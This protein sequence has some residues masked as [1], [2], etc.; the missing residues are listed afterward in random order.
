MGLFGSGEAAGSPS[1]EA[2]AIDERLESVYRSQERVAAL[3]VRPHRRNDG[4]EAMA[5]V[6]GAV[7]DVETETGTFGLTTE[8]VSPPFAYEVRYAPPSPGE[9]RVLSLS[10]AT[11]DRSQSGL[12]ERQLRNRYPASSITERERPFLPVEAGRHVAGATLA[13]DRYALYPIKH[14]DH[15]EF[16]ANPMGSILDELAGGTANPAAGADVGLQFLFRPARDGW[17]SG[18]RGGWGAPD[19]DTGPTLL[20]GGSPPSVGELAHDLTQP[21]YER[22]WKLFTPETVEVPP[23]DG[24]RAAAA[25]LRDLEGQKGWRVLVRL[26]AVGDDPAVVSERVETV[27]GL[28]RSFHDPRTDQSLS[29]APLR[30]GDLRAEL[31][32]ANAREWRETGIVAAQRELA[33]LVGLPRE[34]A[35][36]T[37]ALPWVRATPGKGIQP[38]TPRFDFAAHGVADADDAAKQRAMLAHGEPDAPYWYGWGTRNGTEAGVRADVLATHQFVGGATGQG[39]TTLLQHFFRQVMVRGAGGLFYDPKGMDS[40]ELLSLV[41]PDREDDLVFVEVGGDP[42]RRAG[43]NVLEPPTDAPPEAATFGDAVERTTEDV[44]ALLGGADPASD[45]WGVRVDRLTRD[46]ARAMARDGYECT[47]VDLYLVL[48]PERDRRAFADLV[49]ED[50]LDWLDEYA[51][52]AVDEETRAAARET[53]ARLRAVVENE[54]VR[55]VIAR[56]DGVSIRGV[57]ADGKLVIVRDRSAQADAGRTVATA[58]LRRLWVAVREQTLADDQPDPPQFSAVIDEF[59]DVAAAEAEVAS[60]LSKARSFGLSLTVACQDLSGQLEGDVL[61]AIEGQCQTFLTFNPGRT[62]DA[63]LIANH[64]SADVSAS[65]LLDLS[66]YRI[67]LRTQDDDGELTHSYKVQ[68]FPPLSEMDAA[69]RA[70]ADVAALRERSLGRY[71]TGD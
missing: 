54:T 70:E 65:D 67:Y 60:I 18:V 9:E 41:P 55:E 14:V 3:A 5:D 59:D 2:V 29:A 63:E 31:R 36:S 21:S 45:V 25:E 1:C 68:T 33:T 7:H 51:A 16:A 20:G 15:P 12:L 64:H 26:F 32:R 47:L 11:T 53:R 19:P 13:L 57:V 71:G 50:R 17:T 52:A 40:E 44:A 30:V 61:D 4:V 6:L 46:L 66:K 49:S 35:V 38:G 37:A 34:A 10:Y 8:N 22:R 39:K 58:L 56:P 42:D 28:F 48:L 23:S 27:A 43:F 62:G 24:A 69:A